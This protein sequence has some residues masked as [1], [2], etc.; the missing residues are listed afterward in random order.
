MKQVKIML[1]SLLILSI[2]GGAIAFK[3][4]FDNSYCTTKARI[5]G[6]NC[7]CTHA[8]GAILKCPNDEDSVTA[9]APICPFNA[10]CTTTRPASGCYPFL[11]CVNQVVGLQNK[12]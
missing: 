5:V 8:L 9:I 2:V 4:R 1:L 3:A 11:D 12:Q 10:Y 6:N 7:F